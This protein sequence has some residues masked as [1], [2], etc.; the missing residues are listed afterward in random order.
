MHARTHSGGVISVLFRTNRSGLCP[1]VADWPP[2]GPRP[3]YGAH[4]TVRRAVAGGRALPASRAS[5]EVRHKERPGGW[6]SPQNCDRERSSGPLWLLVSWPCM[7]TRALVVRA[8]RRELAQ[9]SAKIGTWRDGR[10]RYACSYAVRFRILP[11]YRLGSG[12]LWK[13]CLHTVLLQLQQLGP[14]LTQPLVVARFW[15]LR[16]LE[17]CRHCPLSCRSILVGGAVA[18]AN[19]WCDYWW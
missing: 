10:T 8:R 17:S 9:I 19:R 6:A 12:A 1:T 14:G 15:H 11:N 5:T 3:W 4:H 13:L 7:A 16:A 2:A 18:T